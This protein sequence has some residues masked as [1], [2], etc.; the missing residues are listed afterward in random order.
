[1]CFDIAEAAQGRRDFIRPPPEAVALAATIFVRFGIDSFTELKSTRV[2]QRS[3]FLDGAKNL[4]APN[5]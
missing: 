5:P 3:H 4:T 1:M 2:D